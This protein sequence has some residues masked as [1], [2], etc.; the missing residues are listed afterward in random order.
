MA[1]S[2]G[3]ETS[4]AIIEAWPQVAVAGQ[5]G[6]RWKTEQTRDRLFSLGEREL[7]DFHSNPTFSNLK[8]IPAPTVV[9]ISSIYLAA[10]PWDP[11][12]T[13]SHPT[14]GAAACAHQDSSCFLPGGACA[15]PL[16]RYPGCSFSKSYQDASRQP[17]LSHP[18][19]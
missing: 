13:L 14:P 2:P 9:L 16:M 8:R 11:P 18:P 3:P 6:L 7:K 4:G 17:S 1:S 15:L 5:L 19:T 12:V 10:F